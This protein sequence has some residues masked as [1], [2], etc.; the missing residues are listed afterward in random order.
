MDPA[1]EAARVAAC[2]RDIVRPM[3]ARRGVDADTFL[4]ELRAAYAEPPR[5]YHTFEHAVSVVA[6]AEDLAHEAADID[7]VRFAALFHDAVHAP[8]ER[9]DNERRSADLAVD[10]LARCGVGD[11]RFRMRVAELVLVTTHHD[12]PAGDRDAAVLS[13]ADYRL[14]SLPFDD[15]RA[16]GLRIR[17]EHT[18]KT[19]AEW[20]D[21]HR[22]FNARMLARPSIYATET[23]RRAWEPI[24]RANLERNVRMLSAAED[25]PL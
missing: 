13:D 9:G 25:R 24:A 3:L 23:A 21:V 22:A 5:H 17:A 20:D 19:D 14:L 2:L 18:D 6:W 10:T 7:A 11:D 12:P 16:L 15:Y 1:D 4:A 8:G